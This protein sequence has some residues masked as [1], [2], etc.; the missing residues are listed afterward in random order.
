VGAYALLVVAACLV[1]TPT[2]I[3]IRA[4]VLIPL[5]GGLLEHLLRL[6]QRKL[7]FLSRWP[8]LRLYR[9]PRI[10]TVIMVLTVIYN[11]SLFAMW[12]PHEAVL[13]PG[14][15]QP[16]I[17]GYVLDDS[18]G[19]TSML[20]SGDRKVIRVKSDTIT[21]RVL[22]LRAYHESVF[23]SMLR[24]R[25]VPRPPVCPTVRERIERIPPWFGPA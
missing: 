12:L 23:Q 2:Y 25:G 17:V 10:A 21:E 22:C 16:V 4:G 7:R 3:V 6:A 19:W 8:Q 14:R 9:L 13:A 11:P 20:T 15:T 5:A 24:S 1:L 18:G